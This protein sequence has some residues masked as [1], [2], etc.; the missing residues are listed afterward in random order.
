M[1][2]NVYKPNAYIRN[3][4]VLYKSSN[5]WR[6]MW[7]EITF[8]WQIFIQLLLVTCH[9]VL[10]SS[11]RN[12]YFNAI[13]PFQRYIVISFILNML[14]LYTLNILF[15]ILLGEYLGYLWYLRT[16]LSFI[17]KKTFELSFLHHLN[18]WII[19]KFLI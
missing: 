11:F 4:T 9:S 5:V 17:S 15:E 14:I 2:Q 12:I 1:L 13:C 18:F 19:N 7:I 10:I 8:I 3:P 6:Y 16:C